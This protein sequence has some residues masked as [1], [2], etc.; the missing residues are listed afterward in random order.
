M[1]LSH[2]L[3]AKPTTVSPL[4]VAGLHTW[5]EA[6]QITGLSDGN[7]ITT[8]PDSSGN[9]HTATSTAG[10]RPTYETNE[11]NGLPVMQHITSAK[12]IATA[13]FTNV[14]QPFTIITVAKMTSNPGAGLQR[15]AV[16]GQAAANSI[17]P[18]AEQATGKWSM[19]AGVLLNNAN[20]DLNWHIHSL[21][22]NGASSKNRT[23][24][25]A[26]ATGNAGA[27]SISQLVVGCSITGASPWVGQIYA[28]LLYS[29]ALSAADLNVVCGQYLAPKTGIAWTTAT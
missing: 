19:Y 25:G 16:D 22:F 4:S 7:D 24:G 8:V 10:S 1:A 17:A 21:T 11:L 2:A 5:L 13:A 6:D 26:G 23:D 20:Y 18:Y 3:M 12:A 27:N 9:G 29:A 15:R 14:P 28:V